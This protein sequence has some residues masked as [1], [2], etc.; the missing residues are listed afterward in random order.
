MSAVNDTHVAV[1]SK[2]DHIEDD[3]YQTSFRW[4]IPN[5]DI[6]TD[7]FVNQ[8]GLKFIEVLTRAINAHNGENL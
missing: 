3:W 4:R 5:G 2:T 1:W 6:D 8:A 7:T